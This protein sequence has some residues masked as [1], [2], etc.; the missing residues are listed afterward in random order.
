MSDDS[1]EI[2]YQSF[3]REAIVSSSGK[4]RGVHFLTLSIQCFLCLLG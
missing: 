3:L 1:A 2:L 4:G